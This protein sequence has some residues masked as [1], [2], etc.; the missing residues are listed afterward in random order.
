ML[1][2]SEVARKTFTTVRLREGYDLVEVN[3]FLADVESALTA[4]HREIEGLRARPPESPEAAARVMGLAQE[5]V[6]R[7]LDAA[8]REAAE[9]VERARERAGAVE[10]EAR[11]A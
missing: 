1:T 7:L 11:A 6:D 3:T 2:P 4:L 5:T 9:I 10:E 8:R